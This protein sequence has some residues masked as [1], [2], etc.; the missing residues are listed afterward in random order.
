MYEL[1]LR[2]GKVLDGTGNPW[3]LA[4]VA[5]REDTL[6]V[7][8]PNAPVEAARELDV[9][10]HIVAPGFIDVHTHATLLPFTDARMEP[11][12]RQGVTT[13]LVGL[14]GHS[15][16][17]LPT[18]DMLRQFME[19]NAGIDGVM[20]GLP[21][22]PTLDA[23]LQSVNGKASCNIGAYVGNAT[24]RLAVL[25]WEDRY[26]T[27]DEQQRMEKLLME[28]ME[29]GA[30]GLSTGLTYPPGSYAH[31]EELA[32]LCRAMQKFGGTYVTHVRSSLGDGF[33]DPLHEAIEIAQQGGVPLHISH[34]NTPKPGGADQLLAAIDQARAQG[35]DVTFDAYPYPYTATRLVALLPEWAH[36]GGS[37]AL[38]QRLRD[39]KERLSI[40]RDPQWLRRDFRA[41]LLTNVAGKTYAKY[42]GWPLESVAS[43]LSKSVVDLVCDVLLEEH[44]APSVIGTSGNPVNIRKI[45]QHPAHMV[46]SDGVLVG[47]HCNPRAYGAF[48]FVLGDFCREESLL[49]LSDAIRRMTAMP[50]RHLGLKDRGLLWDGMK[51]DI[52]V[53]DPA[54]VQSTATLESPR[55]YPRGIQYVI[56]NGQIVVTPDGHT[57]A[58]PG[59]A[60]RHG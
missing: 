40:S 6:R 55:Q 58:T 28:G 30:F 50:A 38:H 29:Q 25:G 20:P 24:L 4:D 56:V 49:S 53:F 35:V 33:L 44:L 46:G 17:Q 16:A 41:Y 47:D 11:L 21:Y 9:R 13:S 22:W 45:F 18:L 15:Y 54:T 39:K 23:Y 52:V 34:L 10:G 5:V 2:G 32:S 19:L 7:L 31:Q 36:A 59:R 3:F 26:P 48:P 27:V 37:E 57:G 51:A 12:V 42:D 8:P 43:A 14:D 60:L 1:V